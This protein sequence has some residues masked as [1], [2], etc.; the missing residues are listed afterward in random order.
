MA[1]SP[2][3]IP[4]ARL[5]YH[6]LRVR[7]AFGQVDSYGILWHGH[8][9]SYFEQARADLVR[10]FDLPAAKLLQ[11]GLAVPMVDLQV[12]YRSPARDDDQL[13]VQITLLR[14]ELPVPYLMF[15]YR[16]VHAGDRRE[17]LRG[18]TRQIVTKSDG[19]V[20]IRLPGPVAAC[21]EN[22]W[23]YLDDRPRW[24]A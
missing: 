7:V 17:I 18:A 20:L 19:G 2:S 23:R 11:A 21:L 3:S 13:D 24:D 15:E 16:I 8:A 5:G 9:L 4:S 22:I 1:V 6:S 12:Q 14:P 10:L